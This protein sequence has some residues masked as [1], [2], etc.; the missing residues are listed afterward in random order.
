MEMENIKIIQEDIYQK[1]KEEMGKLNNFFSME[2]YLA[3]LEKIG[4]T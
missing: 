2:E 1:F 3:L 4:G